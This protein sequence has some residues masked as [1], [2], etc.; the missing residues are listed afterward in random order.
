MLT[1]TS[2]KTVAENLRIHRARL[3]LSQIQLAE[4]AEISQSYV[5][6]IEAGSGNLTL[7][8]LDRIAAALG[9]SARALLTPIDLEGMA[10][11]AA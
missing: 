6:K 7:E 3:H 5:T 11:K 8:I 2:E 9:I 1:A 4:K 10:D